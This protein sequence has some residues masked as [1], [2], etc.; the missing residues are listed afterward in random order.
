MEAS[1]PVLLNE[2][3]L[4]ES[5]NGGSQSDMAEYTV[6][7]AL[8]TRHGR[9]HCSAKGNNWDL[10]LKANKKIAVT[11]VVLWKPQ[12]CTCP[13]KSG[14]INFYE[15]VPSQQELL[16]FNDHKG[17]QSDITP[18][19]YF[20]IPE[21]QDFI[22]IKLQNWK[23]SNFIHVK[24]I[25][26]YNLY[27]E[28]PFNIDVG[29][30]GFV[31]F[32]DNIPAEY[33][34]GDIDEELGLVPKTLKRFNVIS[35]DFLE[36]LQ[37]RTIFSIFTEED[38]PDI[39]ETFKTIA[40][41]DTFSSDQFLFMWGPSESLFNRFRSSIGFPSG[42]IA[43]VFNLETSSY[44]LFEGQITKETLI[45]FGQ[46]VLQG[47]AKTFVKSAPR[48]P[49]DRDPE[50]THLY[51]LTAN[52][53]DELVLNSD[54]DFFVDIWAE[55]CGPCVRVG[56]TI[57]KLA[58]ILSSV[59][60][61]AI[62]K[63]NCDDNTVN[64]KYFPENGIPN[65]KIFPAGDKSNPVKYSGNRTLSSFLEF[66]HQNATHKFDLSKFQIISENSDLIAN[67][68]KL[69]EEVKGK[70]TEAEKTNMEAKL[71]A[72]KDELK[73][74]VINSELILSLVKAWNDSDELKHLHK[75][76][77]KNVIHVSSHEEYLALI[78][79]A[80]KDSK[81]LIVDFFATWC[82]PCVALAPM[83]G[84]WSE[85]YPGVVFVKVDVDKVAETARHE[86]IQCMPTLKFYKNGAVIET[87][88]GLDVEKI[89][90]TITNNK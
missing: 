21:D 20:E 6:V 22:Q 32:V 42:L 88:E 34:V 18:H 14:V 44:Y 87:I 59:P 57:S 15:E 12:N 62:G 67:S 65:M 70:L 74:E 17:G 39:K 26:I 71:N 28:D 85:E 64:K 48:P 50:H 5:Y 53:F 24:F 36:E 47:K 78:E 58:E 54:K 51:Q 83:F 61:I 29:Y 3:L 84:D 40:E 60:T 8:K 11:N 10:I 89:K 13:L 52:S 73:K 75:L 86:S 79:Q 16:K 45:E 33:D 46:S 41:S 80:K 72:L 38:N 19:L 68:E 77:N 23:S 81:L 2:Y 7:N 63:L 49:N 27:Q 31:G 4:V 9:P 66:I 43:V 90:E 25:D 82:G 76:K 56:P 1:K 35:D 37:T 30:V 55:W 69:I